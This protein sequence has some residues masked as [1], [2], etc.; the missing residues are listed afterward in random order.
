MHQVLAKAGVPDL[1]YVDRIV[2]FTELG[3]LDSRKHR[4]LKTL[5]IQ[6]EVAAEAAHRDWTREEGEVAFT[7]VFRTM[8]SAAL[9]AH[10]KSVT[11]IF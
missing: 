2:F 10:F 8:L 7:G 1:N 5:L 4:S 3:K 9:G 11:R 6:L